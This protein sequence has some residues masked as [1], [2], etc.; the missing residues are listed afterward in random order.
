MIQA[1][2]VQEF[3][4]GAWDKITGFFS[5][6]FDPVLNWLILL[7]WWGLL[8]LFVAVCGVI[9]FFLPFKWIRAALGGMILLA[10]AFVAGGTKMYRDLRKKDD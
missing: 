9:G 4:D 10:G 1:G 7:E 8:L 6:I 2:I 5:G 3:I